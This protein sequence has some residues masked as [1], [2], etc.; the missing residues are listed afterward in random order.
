M[1]EILSALMNIP[2]GKLGALTIP[3]GLIAIWIWACVSASKQG[4]KRWEK[5][6]AAEILDLKTHTSEAVWAYNSQC[7]DLPVIPKK[8]R[9]DSWMVRPLRRFLRLPLAKKINEREEWYTEVHQHCLKKI[10]E[11]KQS[12]DMDLWQE[13]DHKLKALCHIRAWDMNWWYQWCTNGVPEG[14]QDE[15]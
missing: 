7:I 6:K 12:E 2:W 13:Y 10:E 5:L 9:T 4:D 15:G 14:E 11:A 3:V 8:E 1:E